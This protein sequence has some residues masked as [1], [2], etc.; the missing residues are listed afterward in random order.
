MV[1][2]SIFRINLILRSVERSKKNTS[3]SIQFLNMRGLVL[4]STRSEIRS[5][6]LNYSFYIDK[7][8]TVGNAI[9]RTFFRQ[10]KESHRTV[11]SSLSFELRRTLKIL[12]FREK[13]VN[14]SLLKSWKMRF[15]GFYIRFSYYFEFLISRLSK[16]SHACQTDQAVGGSHFRILILQR[17]LFVVQPVGPAN[18][19]SK[20]A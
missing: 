14:D 6:L 16:N 7:I 18:K 15:I 3:I 5:T 20:F 11:Q 4:S 1:I 9:G 19:E 12:I 10:T 2:Y 17:N 8:C 13:F